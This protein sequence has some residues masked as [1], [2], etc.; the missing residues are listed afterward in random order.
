MNKNIL[1]T[2]KLLFLLFL[3][4]ISTIVYPRN[5][6][7]FFMA[8]PDQLLPSLSKQ[9]RFELLEY[10]KLNRKDSLKNRF[11]E[12]VSG[13]YLDSVGQHIVLNTTKNHSLEMKL[14]ITGQND[15]LIGVINTIQ[16]PFPL[17]VIH[18]Y[19]T[20]WKT[21]SVGFLPPK[22]SAWLK[23]GSVEDAN[24][25]PEWIQKIMESSYLSYTFSKTSDAIEVSNHLT[26]FV[27]IGEKKQ[28]NSLLSDKVLIYRFDNDKFVLAE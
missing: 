19:S 21:G 24:I 11:D 14:I 9:H 7:D 3:C 23:P 2:K 22:S 12:F 6:S 26:D 20:D 4:V 25:D 15:T 27:N 1:F 16:K 28:I 17:S 5:I 10:S 13:L 8:M 18:F